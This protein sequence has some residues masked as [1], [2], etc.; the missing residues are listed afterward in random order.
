MKGVSMVSKALHVT[1]LYLAN[2]RCGRI[3]WAR[4][5]QPLLLLYLVL[6]CVLDSTYGAI[7]HAQEVLGPCDPGFVQQWGQS[8]VT[9]I[10][11]RLAETTPEASSGTVRMEWLGHSSFLLTS[12]TGTRILTDPHTFYPPREPPDASTIS[13]LHVTHSDVRG[14]PGNPRLLWGLTHEQGWNKLALMI[15]DISV[16]N[17]PSYASQVEPEQSPIQNSIFVFRSGGLCLVHLGNLRHPLTPHQLQRLGRP[18]VVMVPA[19]GSWTMSFEDALTVI[20]QLRPSLVI[21]MHID[22]PQQALALVQHPGSHYPVRQVP[23]RSL[24]LS[25]Q[26]LPATTT[27]VL[28]GGS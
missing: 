17:V 8:H 11:Y 9:P 1:A 12:P 26:L 15:G 2:Q 20:D 24:T 25:R 16:F 21:P 13:N 22:T 10:A 5:E 3:V 23:E 7:G 28:F 19:D 4:Q 27:I 14:L 6:L 18:D